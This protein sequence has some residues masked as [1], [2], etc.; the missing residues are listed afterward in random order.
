MHFIQYHNKLNLVYLALKGQ[1]DPKEADEIVE[2]A[3]PVLRAARRDINIVLD[4][5]YFSPAKDQFEHDYY[6]KV[7][8]VA[9]LKRPKNIFRLG[10]IDEFILLNK[11]CGSIP[12][13]RNHHQLTANSIENAIGQI[14]AL[15]A[16]KYAPILEWFQSYDFNP[17]ETM[18]EKEFLIDP[19]VDI[20]GLNVTGSFQ[21][22]APMTFQVNVVNHQ[23]RNIFYTF[24]Y[25]SDD[26]KPGYDE[27]NLIFMGDHVDVMENSC[28]FAFPAAGKFI[29]VARAVPEP[30][31][32]T[33]I[34][35]IAE[36]CLKLTIR[37]AEAKREKTSMDLS[38]KIFTPGAR[39]ELIFNKETPKPDF[40]AAKLHSCDFNTENMIVTETS[41]IIPHDFQ[42]TDMEISTILTVSQGQEIRVGAKADIVQHINDLELPDSGRPGNGIS[43]KYALPI[44]KVNLRSDRATYRLPLKKNF[45][46]K[47]YLYHKKKAYKLGEFF[48]V[49]DISITGIG[50][51]IPKT[52]DGA[53]NPLMEITVGERAEVELSMID[54]R[55]EGNWVDIACFFGVVRRQS[56]KQADAY[57]IGAKLTRL[58]PSNEEL[59]NK[60]LCDAQLYDRSQARESILG[61]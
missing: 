39:L 43:L 19:Q 24:S 36:I 53:P 38:K 26:G 12:F 52:V 42:Y 54:F 5:R 18:T 15:D 29:V 7:I 58:S 45:E 10:G 60:F 31:V 6:L 48:L 20:T 40:F 30:P 51:Q 55:S 3:I 8:R 21:V 23:N 4:F 49:K 9:L 14:A 27:R 1:L 34:G 13:D 32:G 44:R 41:P 11:A 57:S 56:K 25:H 47:G 61:P 2:E 16:R 35:P 50:L 46:V 22:N 33:A 37:E 28:T 59:L 17:F